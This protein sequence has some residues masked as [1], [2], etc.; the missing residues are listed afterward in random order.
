MFLRG[1]DEFD[2]VSVLFTQKWPELSKNREKTACSGASTLIHSLT[3]Q[4][5]TGSTCA[6]LYVK[7]DGVGWVSANKLSQAMLLRRLEVDAVKKV[8]KRNKV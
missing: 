7:R 5:K 8:R 2:P 4:H 3:K 6:P 1:T